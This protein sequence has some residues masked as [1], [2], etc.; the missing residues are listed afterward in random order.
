MFGKEKKPFIDYY[1]YTCYDSKTQTYDNPVFAKTHE[2]I[3]R[4]LKNMMSDPKAKDHKF[5]TNPEDF[6][7]FVIGTF[8]RREGSIVPLKMAHIVSLHEIAAGLKSAA[9]QM[10]IV[11]T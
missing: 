5:V 10:G 2:D 3:I 4:Q 8:D 9:S 11:S 7:I 6:S 1:V